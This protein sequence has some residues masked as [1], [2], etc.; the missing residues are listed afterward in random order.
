MALQSGGRTA[1]EAY[2]RILEKP[3][4]WEELPHVN[5]MAWEAGAQAASLDVVRQ[6]TGNAP[7][8]EIED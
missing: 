7:T 1:Y 6:F 8:K 4:K 2:Q 3:A 5:R